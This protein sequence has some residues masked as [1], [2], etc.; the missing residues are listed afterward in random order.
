MKEELESQYSKECLIPRDTEE[1][2]ELQKTTSKKLSIK[3]PTLK[4]AKS[5]RVRTALSLPENSIP[6]LDNPDSIAVQGPYYQYGLTPKNVD[7]LLRT[8]PKFAPKVK[9][10]NISHSQ[11]NGSLNSQERAEIMRRILCLENANKSAIEKFNTARVI[12]IFGRNANDSGSPEAQCNW[13]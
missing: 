5:K 13:H 1:V 9:L 8:T 12:A 7:F 4:T 6:K 11:V 3:M 10:A 2:K